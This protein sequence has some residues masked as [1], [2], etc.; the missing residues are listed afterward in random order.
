MP[1]MYGLNLRIVTDRSVCDAKGHCTMEANTGL[2]EGEIYTN[3]MTD[4]YCE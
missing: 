3:N 4:L 1:G 2:T